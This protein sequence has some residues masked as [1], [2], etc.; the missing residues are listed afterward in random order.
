MVFNNY[1][2]RASTKKIHKNPNLNLKLEYLRFVFRTYQSMNIMFMFNNKTDFFLPIVIT[3]VQVLNKMTLNKYRTCK[4]NR[5]VKNI[6][7]ILLVKYKVISLSL[8]DRM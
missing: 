7:L 1:R 6:F 5:K 2:E 8:K 4:I 3:A